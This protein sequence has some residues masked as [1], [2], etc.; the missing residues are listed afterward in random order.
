MSETP[1]IAPITYNASDAPLLRIHLHRLQQEGNTD[2][3]DTTS[4]EHFNISH[5]EM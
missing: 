1:H 5:K 3:K 4:V 2:M